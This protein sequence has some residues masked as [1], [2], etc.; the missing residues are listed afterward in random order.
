VL[1]VFENQLRLPRLRI[2]F[3]LPLESFNSAGSIDQ[4]LFASEERMAFRADF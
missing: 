3:V 2:L 4:L 1:Y